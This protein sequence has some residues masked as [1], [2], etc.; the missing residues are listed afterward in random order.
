MPTGRIT[1]VSCVT[2]GVRAPQIAQDART[3]LATWDDML[4]G[5]AL[6]RID[7]VAADPT[8]QSEDAPLFDHNVPISP[9]IRAISTLVSRWELMCIAPC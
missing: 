4:C 5:N 6:L 2:R 1:P 9:V 8:G 7:P 3:P